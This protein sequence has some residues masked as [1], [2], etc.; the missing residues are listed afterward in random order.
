MKL[1]NFLTTR[2]I[3]IEMVPDNSLRGEHK[4]QGESICARIYI[5]KQRKDSDKKKHMCVHKLCI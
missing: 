3:L 4:R 2:R 1:D 5:F